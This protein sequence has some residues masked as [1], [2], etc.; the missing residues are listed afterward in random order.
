MR[1]PSDKLRTQEST[2]TAMYESYETTERVRGIKGLSCIVSIPYFNPV[3]GFCFDYMH[4]VCLGVV[5][6]MIQFWSSASNRKQ[7]FSISKEK[8]LVL[9]KRLLS[10]KPPREFSRRP[11]SLSECSKANEWR[12]LL[13]FTLPMC[14]ENLLPKTYID[15][16]RLLS[17]SIFTI[18]KTK[19]TSAELEECE[20][21]LIRFVSLYQ[22]YY[23]EINM[24]MN[25]HLLTH[26]VQCIKHS[27]PLW[28]QSA[29]AYESFNAVLLNYVNGTTDVLSQ[30]TTKYTYSTQI[31]TAKIS[32]DRKFQ[33]LGISMD[34][35]INNVKYLNVFK[36]LQI[37]H[38]TYTSTIYSRPKKSVDYFVRLR[39]NEIGAIRFYF[40]RK[41]EIYL[42]YI[43][44]EHIIG[45]VD[46]ENDQ[47]LEIKKTETIV[48]SPAKDILHKLILIET[49]S[50]IFVSY[51]PNDFE[52]D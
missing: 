10:L 28:A 19:I 11:R 6:N 3:F 45:N 33:L 4:C 40:Q 38:I 47:F 25:V 42:S 23:G 2:F 50:K 15:H 8:Q 18:L 30:I 49:N 24:T 26:I 9:N 44:Y 52:K 27:G 12:A 7:R 22:Q 17:Y 1:I 5:P 37:G 32:K 41:N 35:N 31:V 46:C 13:L 48:T 16:F 14:L 20:N 34:A 51:F 36:R 29:F 43:L 39:G 21:R